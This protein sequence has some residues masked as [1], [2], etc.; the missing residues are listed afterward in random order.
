MQSRS[1]RSFRLSVLPLLLARDGQVQEVRPGLHRRVR[2]PQPLPQH[3]VLGLQ[4]Q[5]EDCLPHRAHGRRQG[6]L[7]DLPAL[8]AHVLAP[9]IQGDLPSNK[10]RQKILT[11]YQHLGIFKFIAKLIVAI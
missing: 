6:P 10:Q 5:Q 9:G 4:D 3:Q 7:Q 11:F 8:P 2:L 1:N